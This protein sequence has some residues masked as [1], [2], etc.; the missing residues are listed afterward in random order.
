MIKTLLPDDK[1]LLKAKSGDKAARSELGEIVINKLPSR[2]FYRFRTIPSQ[3]VDDA[4]QF[5]M[6]QFFQ[7]PVKVRATTMA[8]FLSWAEQVAKN[9]ILNQL[10]SAEKKRCDSFYKFDQDGNQVEN[11]VIVIDSEQAF[12]R[13]EMSERNAFLLS[14]ALARLT[15]EESKIVW[16]FHLKGKSL[17]SIAE[18]LAISIDAVKK[19][20]QRIL[21][22][23]KDFLIELGMSQEDLF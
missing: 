12:L 20:K 10:N 14:I 21:Q 6:I 3:D 8:A 7:A 19:R 16:D 11:P 4:V 5:A 15:S 23:L 22:K 18:E 1:L 17:E 13:I 9:Y 2:L